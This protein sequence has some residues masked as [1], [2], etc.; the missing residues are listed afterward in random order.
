MRIYADISSKNVDNVDNAHRCRL[1]LAFSRINTLNVDIMLNMRIF[2]HFFFNIRIS[3]EYADMQRIFSKN[4]KKKANYAD[5]ADY[6]DYADYADFS[7]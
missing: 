2:W 5:C 1:N 4:A 6:A 7:P 3:A